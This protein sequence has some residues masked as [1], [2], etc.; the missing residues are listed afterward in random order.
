MET[1]GWRLEANCKNWTIKH[2]QSSKF[3][4]WGGVGTSRLSAWWL[5]GG[6][7]GVGFGGWERAG[8]AMGLACGAW[9]LLTD[10]VEGEGRCNRA[11]QGRQEGWVSQPAVCG[12]RGVACRGGLVG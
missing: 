5:G 2:H 8:I 6:G 9:K 10:P 1:G 11:T 7:D 4:L 12:V 3:P